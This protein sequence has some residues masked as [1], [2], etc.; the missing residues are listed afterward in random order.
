MLEVAEAAHT[1]DHLEPVQVAKVVGE[2]EQITI[3]QDLLHQLLEL[4]T[5]AAVVVAVHQEMAKLED[6]G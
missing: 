5:Q 3:I 4:Q 1:L 2:L 6:L